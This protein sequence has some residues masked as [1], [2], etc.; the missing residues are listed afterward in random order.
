MRRYLYV[1]FGFVSIALTSATPSSAQP[2]FVNGIL[3]PGNLL[4]ATGQPGANGGRFGFFSDIY[5]DPATN[6]WW[7]LSDRGPGGGPYQLRHTRPA[8][9]DRHRFPHRA[10]LELPSARD[11][12]VQETQGTAHHCIPSMERAH[13]AKVFETPHNLIPRVGW[14]EKLRGTARRLP[15]GAC[16]FR[17]VER[18][19]VRQENRCYEG[20]AVSPDGSRLFAVLQDPLIN[21]PEPNNGRP[22]RNVRI[23]VFDN[24]RHSRSYGAILV[25]YVYRLEPQADVTTR[26]TTI[27][28]GDA[29]ATD[30]RQGRNIGVSA[31]HAINDTEF[32]V[33]E[34]DNRGIGVDDPIGARAVGS[35][36]IYKINI[37]GASDVTG[38]PL[39]A[40]ALPSG[41]VAV[42]KVRCSSTSLPTHCSPVASRLRSG[43]AWHCHAMAMRSTMIGD[44]MATILQQVPVGERVGIAF[45]GGLDT[46]AA[47]HWMRAKG[48]I[49]YAYTAN[50]GQP[51][52]PDYDEIP[53]K[54][55]PVRRREGAAHRLPRTARDRR[56]R[57]AP[58]RRLPHLHRRRPLLQHHA[59]RPRR[60]RHDARRS[61]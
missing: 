52:E 54:A 13:L 46:S 37:T 5:Y 21:E 16:R 30:P 29:T 47:L 24:D 10:H 38:I 11:S 25:Q 22:G 1:L 33:L 45:S 61:R 56:A 31:I 6:E 4:D 55:L 19:K 14:N 15:V 23:I 58:V 28:P 18:T 44:C 17:C 9:R 42:A 59:A 48:A 7:A 51:D 35:K 32:L 53:R 27:K 39:G 43:K 2:A 50:L 26:I 8:L 41:V 57:R 40:D 60:H 34:R 3:I 12:K 49:P 36:R 20:L